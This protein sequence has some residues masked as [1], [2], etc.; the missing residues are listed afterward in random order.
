LLAVVIFSFDV[1]VIDL[2]MA[3]SSQNT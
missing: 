2:K 1:T 3:S